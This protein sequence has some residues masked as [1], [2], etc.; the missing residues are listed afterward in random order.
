MTGARHIT[1]EPRLS[2]ILF[3]TVFLLPAQTL[4]ADADAARAIELLNS[5]TLVDRT[6]G[7]YYAGRLRDPGLRGVLVDNLRA[8]S[9]L[10]NAPQFV[11]S[12]KGQTFSP[13]YT[14]VASLL[15]A[16]IEI[17][18]AVPAPN[19]FTA[20]EKQL[21]LNLEKSKMPLNVIVIDHM[22]RQPT[23]N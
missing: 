5:Q 12:A 10:G 18:G 13:E 3:S 8:A 14:F 6:W 23:E 15:D 21:G 22:D 9:P 4:P 16:L 20:L 11:Y 17:R 7:A 19:L 1:F 2:I